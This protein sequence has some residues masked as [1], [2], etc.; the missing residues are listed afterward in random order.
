MRQ[1]LVL[2]LARFGDLLQSKRLLLSVLAEQDSQVHLAVDAGLAR[3]AE[4]LYP[5]A[6]VHGLP[7][8]AGGQ[9]ENSPAA[10][11]SK[12]SHLLQEL[13]GIGFDA[14]YNLNVSPLS[15]ALAAR[16]EPEAVHGYAWKDGQ[17]LRS[18]WCRMAARWT[19]NRRASPLNLV[20]FWA[21]FHPKPVAP[22]TVNPQAR[23]RGGNRI[24][25][26]LAGRESRRSLPVPVLAKVVQTVFQARNG[27]EL[28][29]LGSGAETP[30]VRRLTRDLSS[31]AEQRLVDTTGKTAL[32]DLPDLLDSLDLLI[33]PDTGL[34]HLAAHLGVPVQAFFLS[35]AWAWETGP[36]GQGHMVWQ[37]QEPCAPCLETAP[38]PRTMACLQGFSRPGFL[39]A[40][41]RQSSLKYSQADKRASDWPEN[42]LC[43]HSGFDCLGATYTP[44]LGA[45]A[46]AAER[47][48]MRDA[49]VR[50]A[51]LA[52]QTGPRAVVEDIFFE[53][54]WMLP[55]P[56]PPL[57]PSDPVT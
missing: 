51:G 20:D 25:I 46:Q 43:L 1:I 47:A 36:Y 26:V 27:P 29:C 40:L 56:V 30:L 6:K 45:D 39:A 11:F 10:V 13:A 54:D 15:L 41:A 12:A 38:C 35:S 3:L 4:R 23:P 5:F 31:Q 48:R 9:G 28:V 24:G 37:A 16:F 14:V 57:V 53:A 17:S 7:A 50:Y 32:A 18:T 2:Q 44:V 52:A 34:M 8:H 22:E 19:G 33:T 49:L 42:M 55:D 21:W